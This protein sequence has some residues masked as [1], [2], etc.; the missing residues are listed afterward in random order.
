[1]G[2]RIESVSI[3]IVDDHS[4][5]REGLAAI[6]ERLSNYRIVFQ[7][8]TAKEALAG[9][10][11]HEPRMV[12][13]DI[14]IEG[15]GLEALRTIKEACPDTYCVMF[16]SC[17]D[18]VKAMAALSLGAEGYVLKGIGA[19]DLVTALDGILADR[20]FVSPEFAT[21]LV[22]AATQAS[23]KQREQTTLSHREEQVMCEVQKGLTNRQVAEQLRISEQTVKYYVSSVMQKFGVRNR[24]GAVQVFQR[25]GE[26]LN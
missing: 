21:R 22:D 15:G 12:L 14:G 25:K 2:T 7:G 4:V 6:L 3:G 10:I 26:P 5:V 13:L 24:V 11:A 9:V 18:P 20:T 16:T 23:R 8:S 1:M 19:A 17:E